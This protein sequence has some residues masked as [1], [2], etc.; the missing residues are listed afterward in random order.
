[1][2]NLVISIAICNYPPCIVLLSLCGVNIYIGI[3]LLHLVSQSGWMPFPV[4]P[5]IQILLDVA[6]VRLQV[7]AI[8]LKSLRYPVLVVNTFHSY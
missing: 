8:I 3:L 4:L 7:T 1:M 2:Y 6:I 5:R